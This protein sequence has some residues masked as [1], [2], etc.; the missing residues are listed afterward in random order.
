MISKSNWLKTRIKT[1][2]NF[3]TLKIAE[4]VFKAHST[5]DESLILP[6]EPTSKFTS[7]DYSGNNALHDK[8]TSK[9]PPEG[10]LP[11]YPD[12]FRGL[13]HFPDG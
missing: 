2:L 13:H 8:K 3:A 4:L 6:A 1:R 10:R 12:G 7:F 5:T 9:H 11:Y